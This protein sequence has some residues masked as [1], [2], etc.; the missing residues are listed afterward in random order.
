MGVINQ[1]R[2]T[3][4]G[5]LASGPTSSSLLERVRAREPEAWQRLVDLY[6]P[7]VYRWCRQ[8]GLQAADAADVAQE[9][10]RIVASKLGEF[11]H[12][13]PGDRFRAWLQAITRN[14]L[15]EH[16]RRLHGAPQQGQGGTT[17][18][19]YLQEIAAPADA[20]PSTAAGPDARLLFHR[21]L[22]LV[23]SEF[24]HRTWQAFWQVVVDRRRS[25]DVA[26]GLGMSVQAVYKAKSR[27]LA[28]LRR[29]LDQESG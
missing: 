15:R 28:R 18:Q 10:F 13:R 2:R 16:F 29:E 17:A 8:S 23:Q 3:G 4:L 6:G 21:G 22:A 20:E 9:V 26:E 5:S 24:E 25:V 19:Q 7:L 11:H 12:D 27:V 14:K 1:D